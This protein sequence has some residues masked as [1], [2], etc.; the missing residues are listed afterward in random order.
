MKAF[1]VGL[2][3]RYVRA[4]GDGVRKVCARWLRMVG[5]GGCVSVMVRFVG[6]VIDCSRALGGNDGRS[7]NFF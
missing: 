6:D 7:R 5:V 2:V 4:E 3:R 1:R